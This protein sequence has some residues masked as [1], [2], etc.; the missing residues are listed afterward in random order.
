MHTH[1]QD[2]IPAAPRTQTYSYNDYPHYYY[3]AVTITQTITSFAATE[4]TMTFRAFAASLKS[5]PF[6]YR[7][8]SQKQQQL[9]TQES[10]YLETIITIQA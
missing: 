1:D 2:W 7:H 10:G 4:T 9:Q 3:P 5:S 6:Y 8:F